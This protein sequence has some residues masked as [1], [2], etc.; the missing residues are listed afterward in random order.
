MA[1]ELPLL[2]RYSPTQL[3]ITRS[4]LGA[5]PSFP[6]LSTFVPFHPEKKNHKREILA[7]IKQ[8]QVIWVTTVDSTSSIAFYLQSARTQPK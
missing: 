6:I 4:L 3:S 8:F 1:S 2:S 5:D 7:N